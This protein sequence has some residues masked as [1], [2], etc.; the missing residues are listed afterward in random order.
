MFEKDL[1]TLFCHVHGRIEFLGPFQDVKCV[2]YYHVPRTVYIA[3]FSVRNLMLLAK[4]Q[5]R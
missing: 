1:E 2:Y 4:Y 3:L 5:L